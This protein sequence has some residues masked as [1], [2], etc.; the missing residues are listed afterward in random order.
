MNLYNYQG[1]SR[2]SL[3]NWLPWICCFVYLAYSSL[4][5][6]SILLFDCL[7]SSF[8]SILSV[9]SSNWS[10]IFVRVCSRL[11][12]FSVF[13]LDR[14]SIFS[15]GGNTSSSRFVSLGTGTSEGRLGE[16]SL[17]TIS[18]ARTFEGIVSFL[19][20]YQLQY[21]LPN[22][23]GNT[24]WTFFCYLQQCFFS[25]PIPHTCLNV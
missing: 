6:V 21:R 5:F 3:G 12:L 10:L 23:Y 7:S 19:L 20:D 16:T 13:R 15:F 17:G 14:S 9:N 2:K 4:K 8:I 18:I 22:L 11:N 24:H 1:G 25:F